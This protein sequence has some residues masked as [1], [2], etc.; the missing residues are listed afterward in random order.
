MRRSAETVGVW[1]T[2]ACV[3]SK[4]CQVLSRR[5]EDIRTLRL[6]SGIADRY[7]LDRAGAAGACFLRPS[8][9]STEAREADGADV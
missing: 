7:L 4:H 5:R 8:N 6:K 9:L 1:G 3:M 2:Y